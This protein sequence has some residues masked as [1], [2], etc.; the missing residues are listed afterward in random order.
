MK[1]HSINPTQNFRRMKP[2]Y[3]RSPF[4]TISNSES[5]LN[6]RQ[7]QMAD[8]KALK[9]CNRNFV[10][11]SLSYTVPCALGS[12]P[13]ASNSENFWNRFISSRNLEL[14]EKAG[15]LWY[16]YKEICISYFIR[17]P[18]V[19]VLTSIPH[20]G[21]KKNVKVLMRLFLHFCK[22]DLGSDCRNWQCTEYDTI[23]ERSPVFVYQYM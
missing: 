6:V 13:E 5:M 23:K 12:T 7:D 21:D 15:N 19:T 3:I 14:S 2:H 20:L 16:V 18:S 1:F 10:S 17:K 22:R 9:V 11:I 4:S 8:G